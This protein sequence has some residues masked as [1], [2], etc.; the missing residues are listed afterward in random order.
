MW[1]AAERGEGEYIAIFV[2]WYW[3]DEYRPRSSPISNFPTTIDSIKRSMARPAAD[4]VAG[5]QDRRVRRGFEWLFDQ[6]YPATPA[7]A[8]RVPTGQ[9]ADLADHRDGGGQQRL[10]TPRGPADHRL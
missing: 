7:L 5:E 8:F 9:A 1:Q 4:A 3:Q 2:P 6:E 10:P